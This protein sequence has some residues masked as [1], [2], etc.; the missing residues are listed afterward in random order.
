MQYQPIS[1][2]SRTQT[3]IFCKGSVSAG[4]AV[5]RA[6]H[7]HHVNCLI[8][9]LTTRS[10]ARPSRTL[11]RGLLP[12]GKEPSVRRTHLYKTESA[13]TEVGGDA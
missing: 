5:W 8:Q 1:V 9:L 2:S 12:A 11:Q 10:R 3:C 4:A 7:P 13:T 6:E